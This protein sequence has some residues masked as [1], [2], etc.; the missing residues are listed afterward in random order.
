MDATAGFFIKPRLST[1]R[2][3]P[4]W[5]ASKRARVVA[6]QITIAIPQSLVD[7]LPYF[8]PRARDG[9]AVLRGPDAD[10]LLVSLTE[11]CRTCAGWAHWLACGGRFHR[12]SG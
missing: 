10:V 4:R 11:V 8:A 9:T 12:S 3:S 2:T 1:I 6:G 5:R 7:V